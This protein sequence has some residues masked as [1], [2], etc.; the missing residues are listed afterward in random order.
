M[1]EIANCTLDSLNLYEKADKILQKYN[2]MSDGLKTFKQKIHSVLVNE[3][4]IKLKNLMKDTTKFSGSYDLQIFLNNRM[5]VSDAS[6]VMNFNMP[7][8]ETSKGFFKKKN[9]WET[10]KLLV[11][12]KTIFE[13]DYFV[14]LSVTKVIKAMTDIFDDLFSPF[15]N[16]NKEMLFYKFGLEYYNKMKSLG[17]KLCFPTFDKDYNI[18]ELADSY[19]AISGY[20]EYSKPILVCSNDFAMKQICG[21]ILVV[22]PNNTGKTVY[23]RSIGIAQVFA[24]SGLMVCAKSANIILKKQVITC[25]ASK[26]SSE[27][28]GGRFETEVRALKFI[29]DE[30]DDETLVIINEIFQSTAVDEGTEALYDVLNYM[31]K[32]DIKWVCVSHFLDLSNMAHN[33]TKTSGKKIELLNSKI[34]NNKFIIECEL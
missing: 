11:N 28:D 31:A 1:Q 6:I 19:L 3:G 24:Q 16:T 34:V 12:E 8:N 25:Y 32:K 9:S 26:E 17:L 15:T 21:G 5:A 4:Y 33:F 2:V 20:K 22:G 29:I 13:M 23:T 27:F 10:N 18:S 7:A 30:S 14:G